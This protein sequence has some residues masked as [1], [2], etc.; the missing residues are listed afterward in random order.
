MGTPF[1]SFVNVE[2][3]KRLATNV[4]PTAPT[5]GQ[6]PVFTGVGLLIEN[7]TLAQAGIQATLPTGNALTP[8]KFL[9]EDLTWQ[10]MGQGYA[11]FRK[12]A[13]YTVQATDVTLSGS[14]ILIS[15]IALSFTL[16]TPQSLGVAIGSSVTIRQ[17]SNASPSI[18]AGTGV[19]TFEGDTIFVA[20]HD[21]K[22]FIAQSNTSWLVVGG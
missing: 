4:S 3:P 15:D 22:T 16:A 9:R 1:E 10:N 6:V 11:I 17:G 7:K 14:T 20:V 19:P 8:T 12:A 5:A 18:V 2:L 13:S 21:T